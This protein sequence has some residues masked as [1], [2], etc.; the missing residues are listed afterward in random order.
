MD[1]DAG[2]ATGANAW[3][4][5]QSRTLLGILTVISNHRDRAPLFDAV[6]AA[7]DGVL[8]HDVMC[9]VLDGPAPGYMSAY[10]VRPFRSIPP[11]PRAQS[12]LEELFATGQPLHVRS[13]A[14]VA[15]RP[16]T[17]HVLERTGCHS[18]VALPLLHKGQVMAALLL[19]SARPHAYDDLDMRFAGE[20][21]QIVAVALSN[22]LAYEALAS[23]HARIEQE[24]AV[25]RGEL[26][27]QVS[28]TRIVGESEGLR[29]ALRLVELVAP[30]DAT[31]LISGETGT[32]KELIAR[33]VHAQSTRA[34][35]PLVTLNCAAIPAGLVESELFGHEQGAFTDASRRRR[36]RFEMAHR[37][38]LFLD[39][40]GELPAEAQ[41]K[42]LR[43]LQTQEF[44]RVGGSE[45]IK[46]DV[47]VIA[48][49]NRDLAEMVAAGRFRADL[50]YRLAVFPVPLP[51][52]RDRAADIAPLARAF[53]IEIA[54]RQGRRLPLLDEPG[55]RALQHYDWPGNVRELQNV[56]ERAILLSPA[57]RLDV[58]LLLPTREPW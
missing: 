29:E 12:A 20:V 54:L 57:Q 11:M 31:V 55:V 30:T 26:D 43:V 3:S 33:A 14:Q 4:E 9:V 50:Y 32:G 47:R 46:T 41:A 22:C 53:A 34:A 21:A 10:V 40:I 27:A 2:A 19:Q 39:E 37:S 17:L 24:N 18:Y 8:H 38:T 52:L 48:A 56:I 51:P 7:L 6:G 1:G 28:A 58:E 45:T 49:T 23:A 44:E 35:R 13:R 25:L 16:G 5:A 15:D 36:G 42:L